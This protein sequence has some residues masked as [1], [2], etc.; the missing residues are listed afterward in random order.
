[1]I[2]A[3]IEITGDAAPEETEQELWSRIADYL[4]TSVE[5]NF[6]QGGRPEMWAQKK[7]GSASFLV[8]TGRMA[9]SNQK[10]FGE[11]FAELSNPTPYAIFHQEG[12]I[13]MRQ[14]E[15]MMFQDEDVEW[16]ADEV[17]EHYQNQILNFFQRGSLWL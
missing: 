10:S 9:S 7:D 2:D 4:E 17:G 11:N 12:T 8:D 16:I 3:A 15:F 6:I 13:R 1:M 5:M 14:R